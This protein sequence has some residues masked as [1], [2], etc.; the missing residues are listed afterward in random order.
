VYSARNED[1]NRERFGSSGLLYRAN[2]LMFDRATFTL[3]HNLTGEAVLGPG[4]AAGR[5]LRQLPVTVTSWGA[6]RRAHPETTAVVLPAS[7][8]ARWSFDYLPGA[9]DRHRAGVRFPVWQKSARLPAKTEILGVRIGS[10]AK[11]YPLDAATAA[12]VINDH[13]GGDPVVV[14]AA[15][16]SG[17]L[18]IYRRGERTFRRDPDG[19]LRDER[20]RV[21]DEREGMLEPPA[22]SAEP[23]LERLPSLHAFW[24]G[25]FGFFPETE[26]WEPPTGSSAAPAEVGARSSGL[27]CPPLP[28]GDVAEWLKAAV[29]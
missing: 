14:V 9:A 16:E 13:I 3:W 2:K 19:V 12:G 28:C 8:G 4:A 25:W 7:H 21:W 29:C 1:A 24:F 22:G 6:W 23:P 5:R 26:V 20:G 10:A 27:E 17:T 11:A 18:R 15:T